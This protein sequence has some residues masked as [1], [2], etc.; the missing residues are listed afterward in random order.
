M[1]LVKPTSLTIQKSSQLSSIALEW[2]SIKKE[3]TG[4]IVQYCTPGMSMYVS[5]NTNF[6]WNQNKI[7]E[8][9]KSVDE[10][11]L[12]T[13]RHRNIGAFVPFSFWIVFWVPNFS[14]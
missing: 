11:I 10:T 12:N 14:G 13:E 7:K 5:G 8:K 4:W 2:V 3:V 1:S 9:I 6:P